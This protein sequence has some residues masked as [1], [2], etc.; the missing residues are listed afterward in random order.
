M[1]NLDY[2]LLNNKFYNHLVFD[3]SLDNVSKWLFGSLYYR[4][5]INKH[6][7]YMKKTQIIPLYF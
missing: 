2:Y 4:E 3:N 1:F 7:Y 6:T 5:S